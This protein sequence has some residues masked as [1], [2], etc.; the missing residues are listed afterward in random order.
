MLSTHGLSPKTTSSMTS[1]S[2]SLAHLL[3]TIEA[4]RNVMAE[5]FVDHLLIHCQKQCSI[6]S[7]LIYRLVGLSLGVVLVVYLICFTNGNFWYME[8]FKEKSGL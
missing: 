6:W 4:T 8:H 7:K 2:E 3:S 1:F 5:E